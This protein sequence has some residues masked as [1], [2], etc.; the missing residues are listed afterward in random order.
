VNV[1]ARL[2]F[3]RPVFEDLDAAELRL[4]LDLSVSER[5]LD[6]VL[7]SEQRVLKENVVM[8]SIYADVLSRCPPEINTVEVYH[9]VV[10]VRYPRERELDE[11]ASVRAR[12]RERKRPWLL[13]V[14]KR[15]R[16]RLH[17]HRRTLH[18]RGAFMRQPVRPCHIFGIGYGIDPEI[19]E[20]SVVFFANFD[21]RMSNFMAENGGA[22]CK[23]GSRGAWDRVSFSVVFRSCQQL[24]Y[25]YSPPRPEDGMS[26][27]IPFWI[28]NKLTAVQRI[29]RCGEESFSSSKRPT[30]NRTPTEQNRVITLVTKGRASSK[31]HVRVVSIQGSQFGAV[32]VQ[33]KWRA[34]ERVSACDVR[35]Y[36]IYPYSFAF[37]PTPIPLCHLT[38]ARI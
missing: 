7:A 23:R 31:S 6:H 37:P 19:S 15:P 34:A 18:A 9:K 24:A 13:D 25:V 28:E 33:T 4:A 38:L 5:E 22:V 26:V 3:R 8:P 2:L 35:M 36:I 17:R 12:R 16:I 1:E 21:D 32:P 30:R 11:V 10:R 27:R 20:A 29:I 14:E